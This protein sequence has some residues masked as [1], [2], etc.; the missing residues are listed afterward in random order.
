MN[1]KYDYLLD[2]EYCGFPGQPILLELAQ[3]V[4]EIINPIKTIA[5]NIFFIFLL[6]N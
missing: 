5:A 4:R 6:L 3:A 2:L 1:I